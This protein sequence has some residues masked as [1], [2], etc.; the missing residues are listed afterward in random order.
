MRWF[1]KSEIR[2]VATILIVVITVTLFNL[3]IAVRRARDVQRRG[4]LGAISDALDKF[5]ADYGFFPPSEGGKIKFCKASNFDAILSQ[6]NEK[7]FFDREL[8]FQ[9]LRLC[10]W[11]VDPFDDVINNGESYMGTLPSDPKSVE[12]ISYYYLSNTKRYQIY[13]YLEGE[14]REIGYSESI[15]ARSL[16][17]GGKVCS[18]GKSYADTS[19][20]KSIEEYEAELVE[21]QSKN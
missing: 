8:F 13:S 1:T 5:Y 14:K 3:S 10:E 9:G 4:D 7:L 18:F 12:N 17:C 19:L 6:V 2:G 21:K 11:G 16:A 20:D 15:L